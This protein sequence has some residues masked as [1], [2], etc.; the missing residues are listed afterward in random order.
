MYGQCR[1]KKPL[2]TGHVPDFSLVLDT[3]AEGASSSR[4]V[5]IVVARI[6]V[7]LILELLLQR[8]LVELLTKRELSIDSFLRDAKV[9]HV[10]E[11]LGA[12]RLNKGVGKL[13]VAFGCS[14]LG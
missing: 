11:A 12:N 10:E 8:E 2:L 13:F 3:A 1:L 9:G 14:I 4:A 6:K 5:A 7:G